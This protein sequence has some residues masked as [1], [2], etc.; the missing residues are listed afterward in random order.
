MLSWIILPD[1][2]FDPSSRRAVPRTD[3]NLLRTEGDLSCKPARQRSG[4]LKTLSMRFRRGL[5][6]A[7][8]SARTVYGNLW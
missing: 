2:D 3:T 4:M 8:R 5:Q 1:P 6:V 7:Y